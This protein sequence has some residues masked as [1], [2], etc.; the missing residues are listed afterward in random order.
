MLITTYQQRQT[1]NIPD[2]REKWEATIG[3]RL[4]EQDPIQGRLKTILEAVEGT[5]RPVI[6][7]VAP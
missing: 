1:G 4:T 2:A 6:Q 3:W 5:C 7:H